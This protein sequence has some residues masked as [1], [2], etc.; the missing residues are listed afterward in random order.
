MRIAT[1]L[2]PLSDANLRL[3]AQVGVTDIVC[4]FPGH[5]GQTLEQIKIRVDAAGLK[6]TVVEGYIPH[7]H[8]VHGTPQRD[9]QIAGFISLLQD[10]GHL[11]ISICCYNFMPDDDW[12][13]TSFKTHGR[14]GALVSSYDLDLDDH[15]SIGPG[16]PIE[17]EQMW[18]NLEYFLRR[19]LPVAEEVGV[20]LA[21]HP[22]DPQVAK[23]RGQA[24]IITSPQAYERLFDL[25]KSSANGMCFCQGSFS[26][27]GEPIV[28]AIHHFADRIHYV[29]F[30]DVEG[31]MPK[32]QETFHDNGKTNMLAAMKAYA[33]IGYKGVMR[34][35]HVP[36][37][38][39]E[40][41]DENPGYTM[42]GRLFAVGYMRGLIEAATTRTN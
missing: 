23:L 24:R 11:G 15:Q 31:T 2:T 41:A 35:D 5:Y 17:E 3:A 12:S 18:Y 7:N 25:S 30:R 19:V 39:G 33:A 26:Q 8:I 34:P 6:L 40:S 27:I 28:D 32:F 37:L 38:E 4:R 9:E 20:K 29:H 13:R 36:V 16:G 21:L 14:G 42:L 10:M 1:V 22:D